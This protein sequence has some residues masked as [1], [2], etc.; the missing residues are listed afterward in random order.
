MKQ[1]SRQGKLFAYFDE[2]QSELNK[3]ASLKSN[4][5]AGLILYDSDDKDT[6]DT[7]VNNFK[8][9]MTVDILI[10][11]NMLYKFDAPRLKRL[12]F[13]RKLRIIIFCRQSQE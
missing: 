2:I 5:Q 4:P 6:R 3:T 9:N 13:G 10:V 1:V 7:I 8:K 11:F 12:Y